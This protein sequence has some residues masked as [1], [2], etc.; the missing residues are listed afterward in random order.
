MAYWYNVNTGQI[1]QDGSTESKDHLMGPYASEDEARSAIELSRK[2]N[3]LAD[4]ADRAWK[5]G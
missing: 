4:E 1:E 2:K 5:E 3:E